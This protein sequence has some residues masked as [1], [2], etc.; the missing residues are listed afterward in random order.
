MSGGRDPIDDLFVLAVLIAIF[1]L[2]L[3]AGS[4]GR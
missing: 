3:A 4:A 2:I 1:L